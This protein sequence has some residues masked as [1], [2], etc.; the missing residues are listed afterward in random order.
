MALCDFTDDR[1][2]WDEFKEFCL[3]MSQ[4]LIVGFI[5]IAVLVAVVIAL[6]KWD[7][8][9]NSD[10]DYRSGKFAEK[11]QKVEYEGH[12]YLWFRSGYQAGI[13]HDENCKC[14]AVEK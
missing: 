4:A 13:C 2:P 12:T 11:V 6:M 3:S 14:K 8:I 9:K 5:I 7:V 10:I 1:T